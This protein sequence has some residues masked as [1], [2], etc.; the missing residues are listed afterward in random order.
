MSNKKGTHIRILLLQKGIS[1][2]QI[3]RVMGVTEGAISQVV[4]GYTKNPRLREAIARACGVSVE[5][6]WPDNR[7]A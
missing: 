7:A 4:H 2:A 5:E 1:Q 6:L 3:A